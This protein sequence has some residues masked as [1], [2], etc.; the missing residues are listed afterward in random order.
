LFA[1]KMKRAL[2]RVAKHKEQKAPAF[3]GQG[4]FELS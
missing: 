4:F 1:A 2:E 3:E